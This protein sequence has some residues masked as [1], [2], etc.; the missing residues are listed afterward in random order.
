MSCNQAT[1][2]LIEF[3]YGELSAA[4]AAAIESHLAEC[5]VCRREFDELAQSIELLDR[6]AETPPVTAPIEPARIFAAV[7]RRQTVGARRWRL[8]AIAAAAAA[9]LIAV[10]SVGVRRIDVYTT[11][12]VI[13]WSDA[14]KSEAPAVESNVEQLR[15]D[16][17]RTQSHLAE[18]Q[19]RLDDLERLGS[20]VVAELKEDD[21]RLA[22]AAAKLHL[23]IDAAQRQNDERW[24]AVSRGFHDW[25]LAQV[26]GPAVDQQTTLDTSSTGDLP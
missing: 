26:P 18:Q 13:R 5:H 23:R 20:L 21:V 12:L 22:R 11:H 14:S 9:V 7:H 24:Q 6:V 25:Y 16:L 8:A 15:E 10:V 19:R 17:A 2:N 1:E 4:E 3:V